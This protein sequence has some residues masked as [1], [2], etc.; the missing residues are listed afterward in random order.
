MVDVAALSAFA[1]IITIAYFLTPAAAVRGMHKANSVGQA[2]VFPFLSMF[3]NCTLWTK[4]GVLLP[5]SVIV[6]V[7]AT[8]LALSVVYLAVYYVHTQERD[9]MENKLLA[10][11]LIVYPILIYSQFAT[12]DAA[13]R[14]VGLLACLG[15]VVMFGSPLASL[16][17]VIAAKNA[18]SMSLT[19]MVMSLVTSFLWTWY[20]ALV[21][22]SNIV[23][24]NGLGLV[25]AVASLG[26]FAYYGRS[27]YRRVL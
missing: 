10:T 21:G 22:D 14:H 11:A 15:T 2:D 3:I 13:T 27:E 5:D 16:G 17:R 26:V 6:T 9:A 4:Y 7:N 12:L 19:S 25:L 1:T 20:G 18:S 8:G 23:V 24:P